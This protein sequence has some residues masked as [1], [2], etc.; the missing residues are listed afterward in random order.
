MKYYLLVLGFALTSLLAKETELRTWKSTAGTSVEAVATDYDGETVTLVTKEDRKITLPA[1]KLSAA[2]REFLK[3]HF[4]DATTEEAEAGT[5]PKLDHPLGEIFGP[6]EVDSDSH[7]FMYLPK[8][9]QDGIKAPVLYWTDPVGSQQGTLKRFIEAAELTGV[10]LAASVESRNG[11][12]AG[13]IPGVTNGPVQ[14]R[15]CQPYLAQNF[16]VDIERTF[17]SG[18]SGGGATA[19]LNASK[20]PS[21][22]AIVYIGYI[23]DGVK[24]PR[25]GAYV[26]AGGAQD[27]NRYMSALSAKN[28]GSSAI[29]RIYPGAHSGPPDEV[30]TENLITVY[31]LDLYRNREERSK[32]AALFEARLIPWLEKRVESDPASAIFYTDHLLNTCKLSGPSRGKIEKLHS[33][34]TEKTEAVRYLEGFQA[35][36]KYSKSHLSKIGYGSKN[37]H[38][39][40]KLQ[41]AAEKIAKNFSD[42]PKIRAIAEELAKGTK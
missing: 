32:E 26:V 31:T 19:F 41:K 12:A 17:F 28:L 14:V 21:A 2:D 29:H 13:A 36:L 38:N 27:Y 37:G 8:S 35:L 22:G 33:T 15:D 6:V 39:T 10:V 25:K 24:V 20:F 30:C 5:P 16:P 23:R 1:S 42:V 4:G 34:L 7:M 40:P 9:L 11:K 18:A 3:G